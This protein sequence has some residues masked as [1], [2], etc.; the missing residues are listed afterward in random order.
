MSRLTGSDLVE[1]TYIYVAHVA[2]KRKGRRLKRLLGLQRDAVT[3]HRGGIE[4]LL[5]GRISGWVVVNDATLTEVRLLLGPLLVA[6]ADIDQPRPDVC[7]VLGCDNLPGFTLLLQHEL[8]QLDPMPSPRLLALSADG[9]IVVNL[10]LIRRPEHTN[11][12]LKNL[13]QSQVLGFDGHLDGFQQGKIQGWA[14]RRG[15]HQSSQ[16]WLQA[17]D[18]EPWPVLCNQLREGMQLLGLPARCG[19]SIDPKTLPSGWSG[20][21]VWCSFDRDGQFR[22][23]QTEPVFVPTPGFVASR[24]ITSAVMPSTPVSLDGYAGQIQSV[25]ESLREHWQSLESFSIYLDRL[26][27]QI[28]RIERTPH[29]SKAWWLRLLQFGR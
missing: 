5:P 3:H 7:D 11:D 4:H 27:E 14:G 12:R 8:P 16:V 22:M 21:E 15:Q 28:D 25:P 1:E 6:K 20:L 10:E 2:V 17:E 26:E 19:F 9:S 24:I 13:L 18:H 23:P 29:S